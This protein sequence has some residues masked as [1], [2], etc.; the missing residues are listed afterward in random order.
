MQS[1]PNVRRI[2]R[3]RKRQRH[4]TGSVDDSIQSFGKIAGYDKK[5]QARVWT[6]DLKNSYPIGTKLSKPAYFKQH[7]SKYPQQTIDK[8]NLVELAD[9]EGNVIGEVTAQEACTAILKQGD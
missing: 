2:E 6:I 3:G 8:Y 1:V 4:G 9:E 7:I 5:R